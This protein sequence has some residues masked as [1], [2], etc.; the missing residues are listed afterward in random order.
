VCASG[1]FIKGTQMWG[2]RK[3]RWVSCKICRK[4]TPEPRAKGG[5][6]KDGT[7]GKESAGQGRKQ[8]FVPVV[9]LGGSEGTQGGG[10]REK[11]RGDRIGPKLSVHMSKRER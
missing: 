1:P 6:G 10:G 9:A 3:C 7:E 11:G 5:G 2:C 8:E 4:K